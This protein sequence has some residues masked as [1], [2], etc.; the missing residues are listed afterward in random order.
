MAN[1]ND[2]GLIPN[3]QLPEVNPN[4]LPEQIGGGWLPL[5]QP[6][7]YRFRI[8]TTVSDSYEAF[9]VADQGQR[10]RAVFRKENAL[11][12]GVRT[13]ECQIS[14]Q[15]RQIAGKDV[16]DFAYL[17]H[18]LGYQKPLRSNRDY[19]E[20]LSGYAGAEFMANVDWQTSCNPK[21]SIRDAAGKELGKPGCGQRW[22]L[23]GY[24]KKD[25][26]VVKSIP[27]N[28]DGSYAENF[29]CTCGGK[30]RA[31]GQLVKFGPVEQTET[32]E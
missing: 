19:L 29:L 25:G 32:E 4:E 6:G 22:A 18:G 27:T 30:L 11:V 26:T 14:N 1:M 3:E 23:R 21:R 10:V 31:F 28:P 5:P 8:P 13:F 2:L 12:M 20:A 24:T 9:Q 16:S 7:R 17:L 15:T